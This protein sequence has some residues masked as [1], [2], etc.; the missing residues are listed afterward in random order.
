MSSMI[1]PPI[2]WAFA[3]TLSFAYA[4]TVFT[5]YSRKVTP[6]WMNAFK[7][8]V[9]L[10][11]FGA[12]LIIFQ[13]WLPPTLITVACLLLSGLM[14]LMIGDL[15]MLHA[16]AEMGASR[17]LM[18]FG[19]QPFFL[20][21]GAYFLFDQSFSMWKFVGVCSMLLCLFIFSLETYKKSGS[22]QIKGLI[23]GF[24]AVILDA[25]GI[26]LT[27]HA[28]ENTEGISSVQVNFI[29]CLGAGAGF[30][31]VHLFLQ[32]IELKKV[33]MSWQKP[34]RSKILIGS[35]MGTYLSLMLYLTAVSRGHLSSVSSVTITGPLFAALFESFKSKKLP[36]P[37][38][39]F[40][41][42]FFVIGFIIFLKT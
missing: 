20:G 33:F 21:I 6:M 39:L 2:L 19:L 34:D 26:L 25:I 7:A 29:R 36:S 24:I 1:I 42:V 41:F 11:C 16:M 40:G 5:E 27:R 38:L 22:W 35:A 30:L 4:S 9:A 23:N 12:T 3:A 15:F 8:S 17:M 37:Y 13:I 31:F 18:I 28:F 32:K 14:G 10:I